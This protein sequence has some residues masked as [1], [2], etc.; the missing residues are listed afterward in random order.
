MSLFDEIVFGKKSRKARNRERI[1]RNVRKGKAAEDQVRME[2]QLQGYDVK[3]T[4]K[5]SDFCAR[6]RDLFT[7]K[8]IDKK[9]IEVKSG[10]A[11]LSELQKKTKRK[12]GKKN[13]KV[14]RR[15]PIVF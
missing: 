9:F 12:K 14:V 2:L 4:G 6:K 11:K 3:R 5:G 8:I 7:G 1:R 10:K 15:D 13:Y